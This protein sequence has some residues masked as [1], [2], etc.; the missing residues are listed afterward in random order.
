MPK[1]ALP[2]R[3]TLKLDSS[4]A[5]R[6]SDPIMDIVPGAGGTYIWIGDNEMCFATFG[7]NK[8]KLRQLRDALNEVLGDA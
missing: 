4:N 1:T 2:E 8:R 3:T 5:T 7:P 6:H